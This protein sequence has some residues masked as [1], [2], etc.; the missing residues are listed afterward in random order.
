MTSTLS[1]PPRDTVEPR[2]V[3][4]STSSPLWRVLSTAKVAWA[5]AATVLFAIG[6]ALQLAGA[7]A[8]LWWA[9][10][11][12]CYATGGWEPA[13]AGLQA[14]RE[15][16][17]DVDL[18]MI[19]A[20]LVAASIGQVF[21]GALL[22]VIFST[23]GALEAFVTRRTADSVRAL[24]DLAP[25]QATRLGAGGVEQLVDAAELVVGDVVLV[26]P[27]ERVGADGRV[28][29]GASELDQASG[30]RRAVAGPEADRRRRPGR[31]CSSRRSSSAT[32]P[33]SSSPL[34]R[35]S[36]SRWRWAPTCGRHCC[37]P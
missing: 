4:R 17:L 6:G 32:P 25:E 13:L 27:G 30:H 22:I 12:L 1:S 26:R 5:A 19:V 10:Y 20:A 21:D 28:L 37:A 33:T 7:P 35:C 16:T 8:P 36:S 11:L 29:E 9:L 24:R 2:P 3:A 34:S 15:R 31:S 14:L 23:S 18:L